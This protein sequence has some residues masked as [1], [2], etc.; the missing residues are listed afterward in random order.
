MSFS[1]SFLSIYF[2]KNK[3]FNTLFKIFHK[4]PSAKAFFISSIAF[5]FYYKPKTAYIT[6][7]SV[8]VHSLPTN[9][10]KSLTTHPPATAIAPRLTVP[11]LTY[12][13]INDANSSYSSFEQFG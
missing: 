9:P 1:P 8:F 6:P 3:E 12:T 5:R 13:P 7:I 4:N 2:Y 11:A 10:T